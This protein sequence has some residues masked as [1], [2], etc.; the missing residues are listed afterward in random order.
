MAY[1]DFSI[2]DMANSGTMANA[3]FGNTKNYTPLGSLQAIKTSESLGEGKK[4]LTSWNVSDILQNNVTMKPVGINYTQFN[5]EASKMA[6]YAYTAKI[7]GTHADIGVRSYLVGFDTMNTP[8]DQLILDGV[9][10]GSTSSNRTTNSN[11]T[12][13][14][15]GTRVAPGGIAFPLSMTKSQ[16]IEGLEGVSWSYRSTE[17]VHHDYNAADIFAPT[18]TTVVSATAGK[19]ID[20]NDTATRSSTVGTTV[21][22]QG[23]NG[24]WYYYAHM[25]AN[26][27]AVTLGQEVQPG[28][29]IGKVGTSENAQNTTP[30]LHFDV[31][32]QEN[33]F[34]R[35]YGGSEGPLLNPQPSLI[36]AFNLLPE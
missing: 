19:V 3:V 1:F 21:R 27:L 2:S 16:V 32:P 5:E 28:T 14:V 24:M 30:H 6:N 36:E 13:V 22:I 23:D 25:G 20:C 10:N 33:S 35:G 4:S 17:N 9:I 8:K 34:S 31:S 12:G 15:S 11:Q 7:G 29:I 26:T 18:G